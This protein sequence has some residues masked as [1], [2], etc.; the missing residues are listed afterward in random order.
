MRVDLIEDL[1]CGKS[2]TAELWSCSNMQNDHLLVLNKALK[3]DW[4]IETTL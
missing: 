2:I 1:L 3:L 4:T